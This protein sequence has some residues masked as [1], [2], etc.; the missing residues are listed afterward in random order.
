[1]LDVGR[2]TS[3]WRYPV[4][5]MGGER[6]SSASVGERGL[7]A[8]RT[9]AVR[10]R[11]AVATTS[12]KRLPGLLMCTARY[13]GEPGPGAGP[14]N[15]PEVIIEF[16]DGG[17]VS[18]SDP[19][20]HAALSNYLD[21]EVEL[22]PL[23][24]L[25]DRA[26]YRAPLSTT[27]DMRTIFGLEPDEPLPDL[28]M[29]P[30]RKLIEITRYA[31]P[32]GSYVDAYPVH[33]LTEQA[34]ASIAALTPESDVDVRRFRPT[35]LVDAPGSSAPRPEL[36]WCGGVLHAPNCAMTPLIPTIRCVMPSHPQP[37]LSR[38][39]AI[40][41]TIAADARRCLGVYGTVHTAGRIGEGDTLRLEPPDR[42]PTAPRPGSVIKRAVM[43]AVSSAL[44]R[45]RR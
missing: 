39:P 33:I 44:D 16:P 3:V 12:A 26:G 32:V 40:T 11:E 8:D 17:E 14:G 43:K 35:V 1:M 23:P 34:L 22:R 29:F 6:L 2:V 37:G 4:K 7:L 24:A 27:T 21:R 45:G 5:S 28:S 30:L 38:D 10:D 19:G 9:W 36:D 25:D 41:R 31:T 20:V 18:S 15:A 13:A 42:S